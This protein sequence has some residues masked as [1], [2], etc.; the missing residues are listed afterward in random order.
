MTLHSV[1]RFAK[2]DWLAT[3][4]MVSIAAY[5]DLSLRAMDLPLDLA[6]HA[7]PSQSQ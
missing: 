7:T 1:G 4:T 2:N 6:H 3:V 5:L